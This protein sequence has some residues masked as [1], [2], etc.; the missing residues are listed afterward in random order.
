MVSRYTVTKEL[1]RFLV[2]FADDGALLSLLQGSEQY[3]GP[4]LTEF[5]D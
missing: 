3:H 4:A 2:K 1:N 5:V